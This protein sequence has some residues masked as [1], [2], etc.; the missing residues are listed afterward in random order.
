[1]LDLLEQTRDVIDYAV[2][3]H[4]SKVAH[5]LEAQV[6]FHGARAQILAVDKQIAAVKGQIT[7]TRESLRALIGAGASDMPEIKPVAL[8]RVQTG[9]PAT[10][11]YELLARR[12]DL[13]AMRWYVQ[14]SLDQVDSA[15]AL[16]YPSFDIKAFF[17][18][19]IKDA[20]DILFFLDDGSRL[21]PAA[22]RF[23]QLNALD[24]PAAVQHQ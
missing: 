13:Q 4:Q 17:G 22:Q 20:A 9:I 8:P 7:E 12:P 5:G 14:A 10:L 15:R 3:A 2:K 16:F 18:L 6:P 11:S 19:D 1:M 24:H 23:H 21:I